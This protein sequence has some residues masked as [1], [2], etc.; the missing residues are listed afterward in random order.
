MSAVYYYRQNGRDYGPVTAASLKE[1]AAAGKLTGDDLIRRD[2]T[3]NW[4]RASRIKGLFPSAEA[5]APDSVTPT[6]PRFAVQVVGSP[7]EADSADSTAPAEPS[8]A[9][10]P[11]PATTGWASKVPPGARK[12]ADAL[13]PLAR[14]QAA[15]FGL[16]FVPFLACVAGAACLLLVALSTLLT[17]EYWSIENVAGS[18]A[19]SYAGMEILEGK[20]IAL[21][22][23]AGI[24]AFVATFFVKRLLPISLLVAGA[25]CTCSLIL[26]ISYQHAIDRYNEE[27]EEQTGEVFGN[28]RK[29]FG[30]GGAGEVARQIVPEEVD[31]AGF[32]LYL[33][34]LASLIAAPAFV[35]A[36]LSKPLPLAF[37]QK[38]SVHPVARKHGALLISQGFALLVGLA[39]YILRF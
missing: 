24:G 34:L 6:P 32:G 17:W 7:A 9:S 23:L 8:P 18:N 20:A 12:Y 30:E 37:L 11:E 3:E 31:A 22:S 38:D 1:L 14:R 5:T 35:F 25:A 39:G 2:G 4:E 36:A 27:V 16:G 19:E 28:F 15:E 33:S 21:M 26:A 13:E 29:M 10:R